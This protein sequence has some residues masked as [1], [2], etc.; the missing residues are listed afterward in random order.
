M[1]G[2]EGES[3]ID[4]EGGYGGGEP[5]EKKKKRW[6]RRRT[7]ESRDQRKER[8]GGMV[9]ESIR[10]NSK[11]NLIGPFNIYIKKN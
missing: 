11:L 1:F 9:W 2:W 5:R 3:K 6:R 8:G 7:V 10:G 4:N